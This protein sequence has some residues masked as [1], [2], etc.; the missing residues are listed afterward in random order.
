MV[1]ETNV[2]ARVVAERLVATTCAFAS[3]HDF[4]FAIVSSTQAGTLPPERIVNND[5]DA[6]EDDDVAVDE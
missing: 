5:A 1:L 2:A 6:E 3:S 4:A